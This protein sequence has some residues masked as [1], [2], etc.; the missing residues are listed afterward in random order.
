MAGPGAGPPAGRRSGRVV[1]T[2]ANGGAASRANAARAAPARAGWPSAGRRPPERADPCPPGVPERP[3]PARTSSSGA[4]AGSISSSGDGLAEEVQQAVDDAVPCSAGV[5]AGSASASRRLDE[6]R[7]SSVGPRGR[8]RDAGAARWRS[9]TTGWPRRRARSP[10]SDR[11]PSSSPG[12]RSTSSTSRLLPMPPSPS[13]AASNGRRWVTPPASRRPAAPARVSRPTSGARE[14]PPAAA[15]EGERLDGQPGG[16]RFRP[17]PAPGPRPRDCRRWPGWWRH[18]WPDRRAPRPAAPRSAGGTRCSRRHPS[19]CSRHR[20]AGRR[21]GPRRCSRRCASGPARP[22]AASRSSV[23]LHPHRCPHGPLGVVLVGDGAPNSATMASPTIL[24]TLPPKLSTSLDEPLE[25]AG[26]PAFFT[27]SGSRPSARPVKP[28]RS[29]KSTVT[30]RRS[31]PRSATRAWPQTGQKRAPVGR[32][33]AAGRAGH[34][35]SA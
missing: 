21:R 18:G 5:G 14:P 4:R 23:L 32:R 29:A 17:G 30:T 12:L 25:A 35:A 22:A 34:R 16:H 11:G 24:S 19:R 27:C 3:A 26:R 31:S 9:A 10:E 15:G 20:P 33:M 28:T 13:T 8:R 7:T 1:A 2:R 6:L